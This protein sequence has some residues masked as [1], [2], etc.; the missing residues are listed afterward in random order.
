MNNKASNMYA[1]N[2]KITNNLQS[3]NLQT[4][5]NQ[6]CIQPVTPNLCKVQ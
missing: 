6:F 3:A 1:K 2:I 5:S 4:I